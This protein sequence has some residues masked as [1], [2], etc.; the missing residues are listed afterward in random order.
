M[1]V[2]HKAQC[3]SMN[4]QYVHAKTMLAK[5]K[6]LL[7]LHILQVLNKAHYS[8]MPNSMHAILMLGKSLAILHISVQKH[9]AACHNLLH[10]SQDYSVGAN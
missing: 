4:Q 1:Q 2:L 5:H 3:S 10:G 8:S 9:S 7:N 6:P